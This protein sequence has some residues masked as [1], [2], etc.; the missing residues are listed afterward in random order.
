[1][2]LKACLNGSREVGEHVALPVTSEELARDTEAVVAAGAGAIHVHPRRVDGGQSLEAEDIANAL[3]TIRTRCPGIP[4][5]VSTGIWIEPD[6]ALRLQR[7]QQWTVLPDFASVNFSE[8]G[9]VE[10]C[11]ALA[12]RGIGIE[13]GLATAADVR[14]LHASGLADQCLRILIEPAESEV[15]AALANTT[16][17]I[18]ALDEARI[19]RPRLL[20]GADAAAWDILKM[21]GSLG[22]D[23]RIGLEDTLTLP[24]GQRAQGNAE[25]V[26][27]AATICGI[28]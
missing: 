18:A 27:L 10:L 9:A 25:L 13:A 5:G 26:S 15:E 7:V 24:D 3:Q 16:A 14:L 1:M 17:M 12:A 22:Y 11:Y 21:A 8:P 19:Q 20:H 6:I 2:L 23:T 4:I 28:H